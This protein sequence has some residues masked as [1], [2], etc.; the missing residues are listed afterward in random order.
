MDDLPV[1]FWK[2]LL[3]VMHS[4]YVESD[5]VLL[6]SRYYYKAAAQPQQ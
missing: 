3:L 1:T 6:G 5:Q 2:R 4:Y